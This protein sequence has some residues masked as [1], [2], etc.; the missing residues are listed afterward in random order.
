MCDC[1]KH[2]LML[3]WQYEGHPNALVSFR[4]ADVQSNCWVNI[5]LKNARYCSPL[6]GGISN[7]KYSSL[8]YYRKETTFLPLPISCIKSYF[9]ELLS[10][11]GKRVTKCCPILAWSSAE[12]CHNPVFLVGD[13]RK[14]LFQP[15]TKDIFVLQRP[16][17]I[18]TLRGHRWSS[19][20]L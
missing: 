15:H 10:R 16:Q 1:S 6:A 13:G 5:A 17:G 4:A 8:S 14:Y 18:G 19:S 2:S 3:L 7:Y 12:A 20:V 11:Q 9:R